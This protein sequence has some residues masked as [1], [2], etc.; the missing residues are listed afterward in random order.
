MSDR[1]R[2]GSSARPKMGAPKGTYTM[3]SDFDANVHY[4]DE[5]ARGG[6]LRTNL[7]FAVLRLLQ[8]PGGRERLVKELYQ[9]IAPK[10]VQSNV[11]MV[12]CKKTDQ[13]LYQEPSLQ[14]QYLGMKVREVRMR[15][16][17]CLHLCEHKHHHH[18]AH[19]P[20]RAC[21]MS[22]WTGSRRSSRQ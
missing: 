17:A 2:R 15:V 8:R 7:R 20:N 18:H 16:R 19:H 10:Q 21:S 14:T 6:R 22:T 4:S 13:V 1:T 5:A 12:T 3:H 11:V 9:G